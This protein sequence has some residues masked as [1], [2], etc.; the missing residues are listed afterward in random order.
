MLSDKDLKQL[1]IK[2]I[3]K[4][5]IK[6]QLANFQIGFPFIKLLRPS[7]KGDGLSIF[8]DKE[9]TKYISLYKKL[10]DSK[11]IV[12]FV[13][14]SGAASRM[15]KNLFKIIEIY[16]GKESDVEIIFKDKSFDSFYYFINNI[17]SFAFYDE[18][19]ERMKKD[20]LELNECLKSK[21]YKTI[22]EFI[23]MDHG[24][25][26]ANLP[27]G[28]IK[29]HQYGNESRLA[30]EEHLVEGAKYCENN[31]NNV[32]IHFTVSSEHK[33]VFS[34]NLDKLKSKY[35]KKY[36]VNYFI[37]F[38]EQKPSTD[39]IA[40]DMENNIFRE[41]DGS[42]LFRPGGHGA[43]IENLNEIDADIIYIKNIDNIVPDR[44]K[45]QTIHYKKLLGGYLLHL[46]LKIFD[47]LRKLERDNISDVELNKIKIFAKVDL[48]LC[49]DR[50][51]DEF[52][53]AD[54]KTY[55][56]K[57]LNR[58]IRV[59]GMVKNEGEPGGGPFWIE[60]REKEVSLQIVEASQI[61]A[62]DPAQLNILKRATHFNPVDLVCGIKDYKGR[63]F[64]LLDY[65]DPSTGFISLKS[66]NGKKLKAQELPGL[67][68]GAMAS[69]ITIFVDVPIITFNPV[70][71]VNDLL[72]KEHI[73]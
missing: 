5:K 15:F 32:Y 3:S 41:N 34:D 35:E 50:K 20:R 30:V 51:F 37:E 8:P 47:C 24:L 58:P 11:K 12:K 36:G 68:N 31:E 56:F 46:Q 44:L 65:I 9:K 27:K 29:F 7:T 26:Y 45:D 55:L 25:S 48:M 49:L 52:S 61:N 62:T 40:V 1:Q 33:K 23:L 57:K 4:Q 72:R 17:K 53:M 21:D 59:C 22:L 19:K 66:K 70:K 2:G 16:N 63:T 14:A 6:E 43:L 54:K 60:N 69:W 18:L 73:G 38:S 13:P 64:N 10:Q 67:W 28:L 42:I 71:S 39:T